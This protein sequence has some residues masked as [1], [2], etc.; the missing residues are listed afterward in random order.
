MLRVAV[1][2]V[3]SDSHHPGVPR[4]QSRFWRFA[5][6]VMRWTFHGLFRMRWF[7]TENIPAEGS[8]LLAANHISPLDPIFIALAPSAMGRAIKFLAAA[9]FFEKPL[10]GRFLSK[11]HQIPVRRGGSDWKALEE[12]A[13]VIRAGGLAGIFPEGMV[14]D[15]IDLGPGHRGAARL[16]MAAGVPVIPV[17]VWGTQLRWH[18]DGL[19]LGGPW[20]PTVT[21]VYGKALPVAG[22]PRD[23]QAIREL[24]D[25]TMSAIGVS[26]D[27]AKS[28]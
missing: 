28:L 6:F 27:R 5:D 18:R 25:R 2:V 17:G 24:T 26:L 14:G 7:G 10:V 11:L 15:A 19:R 1:L 9:E 8:A 22:D 12:L 4:E 23:R 16:A 20:R 21:V 3:S 13:G